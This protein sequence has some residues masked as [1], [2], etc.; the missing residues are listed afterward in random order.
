MLLKNLSGFS[1]HQLM[2]YYDCYVL[3]QKMV[4]VLTCIFIVSIHLP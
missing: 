2:L 1:L 3:R 4:N